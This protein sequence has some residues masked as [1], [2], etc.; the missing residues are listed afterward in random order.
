M[1]LVSGTTQPTL[2]GIHKQTIR[3]VVRGIGKCFRLLWSGIPAGHK[4]LV[5]E[6]ASDITCVRCGLCCTH[7]LVKL[8]RNDMR[9]LARGLG[10]S[11][12]DLLRKWVRMTAIGPVLRQN[13]SRCVFL[14]GG[15]HGTITA[16]RVYE[17]RPEVC[18]SWVP[19]RSRRECQEGLSKVAPR[20]RD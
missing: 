1:S 13:G 9:A 11:N 4:D 3:R 20:S 7:L 19:S 17:H 10:I 18:R 16:C 5:P 6:A 12:H 8:S 14:G 15:D 2:T